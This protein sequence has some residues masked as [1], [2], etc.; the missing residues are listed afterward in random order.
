M[1]KDNIVKDIINR[2][3]VKDYT[4]AILFFLIS[5]FFAY[6][7]VK[8]V[9]SIAFSLKREAQDLQAV[10]QV[11]EENVSKV[12]EIQTQLESVRDKM[13]VVDQALP[14][15]PRIKDVLNEI[16]AAALA[17]NIQIRD[18]GFSPLVLRPKDDKLDNLTVH[19]DIDG[20]FFEAKNLIEHILQQRRI[21]TIH[22]ISITKQ[23]GTEE[24]A[25]S[26]LRII[27]DLDIYY[28]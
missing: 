3:H 22:S 25:E 21:K 20:D 24:G 6:F 12:I 14:E 10:N 11:Y 5:S 2:P 28:L 23:T 13:Y 27:L 16:N 26:F 15:S 7:V 1:K 9:L 17:E 4:Y 8:P 18:I 19:V